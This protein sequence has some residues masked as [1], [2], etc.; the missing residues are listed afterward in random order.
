MG[1]LGLTRLLQENELSFTSHDLKSCTIIVNATEFLH[2]VLDKCTLS[3]PNTGAFG[4]DFLEAKIVFEEAVNDLIKCDLKPIFV[5]NGIP[6]RYV[7]PFLYFMLFILGAGFRVACY[8][9]LR[10]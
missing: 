4:H 7:G 8:P 3:G 6:P 9:Q 10:F 2:S 5:F 1:I